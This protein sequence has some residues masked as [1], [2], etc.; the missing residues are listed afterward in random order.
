M[1]RAA[2]WWQA[3]GIRARSAVARAIG[4]W[5]S[6]ERPLFIGT[7]H[8][9]LLYKRFFRRAP[10]FVFILLFWPIIIA[11]GESLPRLDEN[12]GVPADAIKQ[13]Y[14]V[15]TLPAGFSRRTVDI[16][17]SGKPGF[18]WYLG[19]FFGRRTTSSDE[20]KFNA[21]GSVTLDGKARIIAIGTAQPADAP[22]GWRGTAF[23][24][25][26]YFEATLKFNKFIAAIGG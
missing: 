19:Q 12:G 11:K 10:C 1:V 20:V 7:Q 18:A 26:G 4:R 17:H 16:Q 13:N 8:G 14:T 25:G 24:G 22:G 5:Q 6:G 21:D 3:H 9:T 15:R 2:V 23:G